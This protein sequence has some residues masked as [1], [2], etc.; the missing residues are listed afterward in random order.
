MK[1]DVV[2]ALNMSDHEFDRIAQLAKKE[3]GLNLMKGKKSLIA[4]RLSKRLRAKGISS[5]SDYIDFVE[6]G[7][8]KEETNHLIT[9]LTTNVT[10]FFREPHHF[11]YLSDHIGSLVSG[12]ETNRRIRVWSAGCSSGQEPYSMAMSLLDKLRD[13]RNI[14]AKILAT[15][16]DQSVLE[17]AKDGK[18]DSDSLDSIPPH[19]RDG[20]SMSP[21]GSHFTIGKKFQD[22]ITFAQLN[23]IDDWPFNGPFD[24]IFCRNVTIYFDVETQ[25]TLWKKFANMLSDG[26]LLCI[27]HSERLTGP[28][29]DVLENAGVTTYRKKHS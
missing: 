7:S 3:F 29:T 15:D 19:Y 14:D 25:K 27:G 23:L 20:L 8:D 5:I 2:G 22:N 11:Q 9:A 6:N 18:Y 21:D 1:H 12:K 4:S 13:F 26:G 28:A 17:S 16:I 24:I 10:S